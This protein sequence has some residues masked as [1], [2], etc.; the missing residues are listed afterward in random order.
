MKVLTI[1]FG[2]LMTIAGVI[3]LFR[4]DV[5]FLQTGYIIAIMLLVYGIIGIIAVIARRVRPAFLWAAIPAT[6][7]GVV[8]LFFPSDEMNI[9]AVLVYLL[10]AWFIL[11]GIISIYMSIRTRRINRA[12]VLGLIVGII[13]IF[14]GIY[15]AVHPIVGALTIGILVGIYMIEA[16]IDLILV[17]SL[18]GRLEAAAESAEEFV[19]GAREK[20]NE[21]R[22]EIHNEMH[23]AADASANEAPTESDAEDK[24]E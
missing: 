10:A 3:C 15:T 23:Q 6:I 21:V 12:W 24:A 4:P 18:I 8:S 7:I 13:S 19:A 20:V 14:L 11:Q 5:T 16:G 2:V 1:I 22:N 9:H 17:G